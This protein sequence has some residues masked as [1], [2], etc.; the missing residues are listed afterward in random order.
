MSRSVD[1][2]DTFDAVERVD[3][4]VANIASADALKVIETKNKHK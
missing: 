3:R 4:R 2:F 1:G